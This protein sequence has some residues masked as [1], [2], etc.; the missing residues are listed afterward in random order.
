MQIYYCSFSGFTACQSTVIVFYFCRIA[1]LAADNHSYKCRLKFL[2]D[3]FGRK[4][5]GKSG[6]GQVN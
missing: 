5:P 1:V 4:P 6:Q 2:T 3:E